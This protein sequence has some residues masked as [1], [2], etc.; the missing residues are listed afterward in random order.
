M[1]EGAEGPDWEGPQGPA[2]EERAQPGP[3][4]AAFVPVSFSN[5]FETIFAFFLTSKNLYCIRNNYIKTSA[6]PLSSLFLRGK[7]KHPVRIASGV[8]FR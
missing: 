6:Y 4:A 7:K 2:R 1:C 3:L 8:Q 5:I